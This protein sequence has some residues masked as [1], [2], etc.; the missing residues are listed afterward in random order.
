MNR[1][2]YFLFKNFEGFKAGGGF[3]IGKFFFNS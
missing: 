3:A 2:N 1:K